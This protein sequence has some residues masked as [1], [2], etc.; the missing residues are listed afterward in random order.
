MLQHLPPEFSPCCFLCFH[1]LF[2]TSFQ[3][4][5]HDSSGSLPLSGAT[6]HRAA[7]MVLSCLLGSLPQESSR[8]QGVDN[9]WWHSVALLQPCQSCHTSLCHSLSTAAS[10]LQLDIEVHWQ[11]AARGS[12]CAPKDSQSGVAGR[13]H[14]SFLSGWSSAEPFT[15]SSFP[16]AGCSLNLGHRE[17]EQRQ[18]PD[19]WKQRGQNQPGEREDSVL[20]CGLGTQHPSWNPSLPSLGHRNYGFKARICPFCQQILCVLLIMSTGSFW[21]NVA[22]PLLQKSRLY[23]LSPT[24]GMI[25]KG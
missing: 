24:L 16:H 1:E 2:S 3:R 7:A 22:L 25:Q 19:C 9:A 15:R 11:G 4:F 23:W 12:V 20:A 10:Q 18:E 6:C 17:C 21:T 5:I 14:W 13:A 8:P